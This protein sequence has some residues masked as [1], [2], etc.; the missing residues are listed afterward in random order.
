MS[1]EA[2]FEREYSWEEPRMHVL[3]H[4]QF[5]EDSDSIFY[6]LLALIAKNNMISFQH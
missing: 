1:K 3:Y 5:H 6:P 2:I 4:F